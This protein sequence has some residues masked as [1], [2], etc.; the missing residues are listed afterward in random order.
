M[1][2]QSWHSR[3]KYNEFVV[4]ALKINLKQV[5]AQGALHGKEGYGDNEAD[6]ATSYA[7][8]NH[9]CLV[10]GSANSVSLKK[11][12]TCIACK[13]NEA[14]AIGP[15]IDAKLLIRMQFHVAYR[16]EILL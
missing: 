16:H 8:Q 10:D 7:N 6:I 4:N 14:S 3:A 11:Q 5:M 2:V 13:I 1:E 12:M 15:A 9:I